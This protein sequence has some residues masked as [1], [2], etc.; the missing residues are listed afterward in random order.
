LKCKACEA[1]MIH[2][3]ANRGNRQYRYYVC[4]KAQKRG[5]EVCPTRSVNAQAI[6]RALLERLRQLPIDH[7]AMA[8]SPI[9]EAAKLFQ[10]DST[11]DPA[12]AEDLPAQEQARLIRLLVDRVEY[13]GRTRQLAIIFTDEASACVRA[14]A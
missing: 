1:A 13:D 7:K 12:A 14:S 5:H 6:E 8:A 11:T 4:I 3:A 2:S 9:A 10:V